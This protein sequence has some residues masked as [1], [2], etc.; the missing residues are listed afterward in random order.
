M[1]LAE[2]SWKQIYL[3]RGSNFQTNLQTKDIVFTMVA[4]LD[5]EITELLSGINFT[6][7]TFFQFDQ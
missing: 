2:L 6:S 4:F 3:P 7:E 1:W 5:Y